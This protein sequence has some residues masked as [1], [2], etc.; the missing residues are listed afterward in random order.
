MHSGILLTV[1]VS[2]SGCKL[3]LRLAHLSNTTDRSLHPAQLFESK[4][5]YANCVNQNYSFFFFFD[6]HR[7]GLL[8]FTLVSMHGA[9]GSNLC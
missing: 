7:A 4:D 5:D 1:N 2:C 9:E 6:P 8:S 3:M